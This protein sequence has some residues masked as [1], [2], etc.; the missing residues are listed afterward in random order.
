MSPRLKI[1]GPVTEQCKYIAEFAHDHAGMYDFISTH[2]YPTDP[3][4]SAGGMFYDRMD[5]FADTI[6]YAAKS[7]P[8][9][10][11]FLISEFNGALG[12][13][14]LLYSSY[15]AAFVFR[16]IPLLHGTL[17]VFS[18]WTFSDIFE[19]NGM[20]SNFKGF[21]Y[22]IATVG[23]IKKPVYRA[24][25]LLRDAGDKLLPVTSSTPFSNSTCNAFATFDENR[26]LLSIFL[27]NFAPEYMNAPDFVDVAIRLHSA[28]DCSAAFAL[29]VSARTIDNRSANAY[30]EWQKRGSPAYPSKETVDE[31]NAA[32][33]PAFSTLSIGSSDCTIKL[34]MAPF[35]VVRLDV[36]VLKVD[37]EEEEMNRKKNPLASLKQN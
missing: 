18:Y 5:C 22:G 17:A 11:P 8:E 21:N 24:Y 25:E 30:A 14:E 29:N 35:S 37:H 28:A 7:V 27:S 9:G 19:E 20:H 12:N 31:I 3:N 26:K 16:N 4:C 13:T 10:I 2:L 32:S 1:G 6:R 36:D 33:A 23:G 15:A 34:T